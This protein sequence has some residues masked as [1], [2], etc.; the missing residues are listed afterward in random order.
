MGW[1]GVYSCRDKWEYGFYRRG[2]FVFEKV[3]LFTA[4]EWCAL[5]FQEF[6]QTT[7]LNA[8]RKADIIPDRRSIAWLSA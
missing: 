4:C 3:D 8:W 1:D 6:S 7:I 2:I 5:S